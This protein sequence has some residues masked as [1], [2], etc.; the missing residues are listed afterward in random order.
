MLIEETRAAV[1]ASGELLSEWM[2]RPE[3]A[4]ELGLTIDTLARWASRRIGPPCVKAGRKVLYRRESVRDWLR[5][6]EDKRA[7]HD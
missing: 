1:E 7:W 2:T 4:S 5:R 3:L 6:Q